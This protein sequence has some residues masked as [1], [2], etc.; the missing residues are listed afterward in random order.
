[1]LLSTSHATRK[2]QRI[3][4]AVLIVSV[5]AFLASVPFAQTPM[6]RLAG[7]VPFYQS[8]LS[9][10]DLIT[11]VLLFDQFKIR[12]LRALL[13]LAGAYLFTACIA[14]IHTLSFPGLFSAAG[15]LGAGS[16]T[17]ASLYMVWHGGFPAAVTV[18]SSCPW[19][20]VASAC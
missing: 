9:T 6:A 8:A 11:A 10:N 1:M 18:P 2:D 14:V 17:T 3:A 19:L 12:R 15:L 7:F 4:L 13:L 20:P 16:Q 5:L